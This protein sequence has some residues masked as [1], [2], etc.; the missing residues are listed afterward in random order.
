MLQR[1][2]QQ[3]SF[4]CEFVMAEPLRVLIVEDSE[5][6]VFLL[7]RE[8]RREGFTPTIER[9]DTAETM[10]LALDGHHWD[11]ILCDYS[12]PG[13]DGA[14]ALALCHKRGVDIPFIVV[15]G[16][17]GEEVAVKMMKAGAH[18]YV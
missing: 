6:D 11:L 17:I 4:H 13:F 10:N 5:D 3:P 12:L 16:A 2:S 7:A 18:D 1:S 15:S 14:E 9:V 8:L